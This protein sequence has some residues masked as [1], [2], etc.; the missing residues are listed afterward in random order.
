MQQLSGKKCLLDT[1]VLVALINKEHKEHQKAVNLFEKLTA[2]EFQAFISS[3]N[4]FELVAVLVHGYKILRNEAARSVELLSSDELL[5]IV[6]PDYKTVEKFF[7]L[8]K[9]ENNIHVADLFLIATAISFR[10]EIIISG[11]RELKNLRTKE[12]KIFNPFER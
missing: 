5:E 4:L 12:I 6:Y 3:Q 1:N 2:H 11:D 10:I 9:N 7:T 8:V